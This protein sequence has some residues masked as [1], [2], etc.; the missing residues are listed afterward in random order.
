MY[1]NRFNK[2]NYVYKQGLYTFFKACCQNQKIKV[3]HIREKWDRIHIKRKQLLAKWFETLPLMMIRFEWQFHPPK[4]YPISVFIR[5]YIIIMINFSF[6][7][8][9]QVIYASLT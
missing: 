5:Y 3:C 1:K 2:G 8:I 9:Y 6:Q 7:I 4:Y